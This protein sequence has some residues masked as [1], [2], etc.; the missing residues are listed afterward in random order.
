MLSP[1]SLWTY[2]M[3]RLDSGVPDRDAIEC[4]RS[5]EI[6]RQAG[7][8]LPDVQ[9]RLGG[10]R[11]VMAPQPPSSNNGTLQ[12]DVDIPDERDRR[13]GP[14]VTSL[15]ISDAIVLYYIKANRY[16]YY[17]ADFPLKFTDPV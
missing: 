8:D 11:L 4:A 5:S 12:S 1:G 10:T 2:H 14:S 7:E 9:H 3:A 15:Y 16:V 13:Y 6:L 17:A